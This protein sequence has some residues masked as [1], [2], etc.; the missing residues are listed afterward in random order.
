MNKRLLIFITEGETDQE[1]YQALIDAEKAKRKVTKFRFDKI[2]HECAY[3]IGRLQKKIPNKIKRLYLDDPQYDGF[4][5]VAV[6]AYDKDVFYASNP[7]LDR[8][9]LIDD[10]KGMGI[11]LVI[12]IEADK[13]IEDFFVIDFEGIKKFLRKPKHYK[14]PQGTGLMILKKMF[15]ESGRVYLKGKKVEGLISSLDIKHISEKLF[16]V[17]AALFAELF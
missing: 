10:L 16:D 5:K 2:R 11:N 13:T 1:F 7:P 12:T 17:F 9:Q 6:L 14:R 8:E 4:F 3:G 15:K